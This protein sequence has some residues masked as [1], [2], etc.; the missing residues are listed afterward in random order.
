LKIIS[1]SLFKPKKIYEHRFWDE[2]RSNPLRYWFNIPSLLIANKILY[3]DFLNVFYVDNETFDSEICELLIDLL[4]DF[5]IQIRRV[6]DDYQD[7]GPAL[8]RLKPLWQDVDILLSRDID[9]IPNKEEYKSFVLFEKSTCVVSTIRSHENHY[10]YPCRMLIGL[11]SFKPNLIEED[12]KRHSFPEFRDFYNYDSK[13]WDNDQLTV[14]NCFT[15][16]EK[17]TQDNFLDIRI[18]NQEFSQDFPCCS[19][20]ENDL[21][22]VSISEEKESLFDLV[23]EYG[24]TKWAGQPCDSR[25]DFLVEVCETFGYNK[26][27]EKISNSKL[28]KFYL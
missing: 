26:V 8:W 20:S 21:K 10:N 17:F 22:S 2:D 18:N 1:Y 16:D 12:I 25:G 15:K 19:L 3:P 23:D 11:S 7:H 5:K 13:R 28:G 27:L 9:S 6:N 4:A 24:L 14:I